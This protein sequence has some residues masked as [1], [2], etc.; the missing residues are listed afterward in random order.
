MK[1]PYGE[2][3]IYD[4]EKHI[5]LSVALPAFNAR[6]II[7]L[8]LESLCRQILEKDIYWELLICEE[9]SESIDI[10]KEYIPRLKSVNCGRLIYISVNPKKEGIVKKVYLLLEKWIKMA[11]L[12]KDTS[13]GYILMACDIYCH[14]NRLM[15]HYNHFINRDCIISTQRIGTFYNIIT[16]KQFIYDGNIL[17]PNS[18]TI[19]LNM[20]FRL[21]H[22]KH[23]KVRNI[24]R[25]I[26]NYIVEETIKWRIIYYYH[27]KC[28]L[29]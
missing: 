7:W 16:G 15:V 23:L 27:N 25:S 21:E 12:S 6:D 9:N 17:T 24:R 22:M 29:L 10:I 28:Y 18:R 13:I 3:I 1:I 19:H 5:I 20:A 2:H 8:S 11:R 26:D 4:T 14:P